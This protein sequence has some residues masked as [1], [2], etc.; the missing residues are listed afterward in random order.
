MSMATRAGI[1]AKGFAA[2]LGFGA[3]VVA[4]GAVREAL[5]RP[6]LGALRAEQLETIV[7]SAAVL[8]LIVWFVRA[9][10]TTRRQALVLGVAWVVLTL[11]FEFGVF[12]LALGVPMDEL[13][14]AFDLPHGRLWPLFL[15]TLLVG[16]LLARRRRSRSGSMEQDRQE[17]RDDQ[18][19]S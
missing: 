14:A 13:L 6:R 8:A 4:L 17:P 7:A 9:T 2:W 10:R 15:L 3:V 16:P 1:Y 12:H 19:D 11:L 5:L 18:K